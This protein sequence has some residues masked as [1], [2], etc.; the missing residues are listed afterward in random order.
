MTESKISSGIESQYVR[1]NGI[2]MHVMQSGVGPALVMIHGGMSTA[3]A[4]FSGAIQ[5]LSSNFKIIA[6]DSRGHGMTKNP[7]RQLSYSLMADDIAELISKIRL[8]HPYVFGWSDGGQI[9]L[10]L[11]IR[12]PNLP[13][14]IAVGGAYIHLPYQYID[15][16]MSIGK[17]GPGEIDFDVLSEN[18]PDVVER[19]KELHSGQG[20]DYW[21]E[22]YLALS[23]AQMNPPPYTEG[24]LKKIIQP[25]LIF[26]GDR[27]QFIPVEQ[28]IEMY[29]LIPNA[30]LAIVPD[31]DHSMGRNPSLIARLAKEFFV[32]QLE[33]K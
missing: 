5:E 13:T 22:L 31:T 20:E 4:N 18:I 19:L 3:M 25:T 17:R 10:D 24:D 28:A 30:E 21:K 32:K 27:D 33:G 12:Y 6:P 9:A 7:V 15:G 2:D 16:A 26:L 23:H 8:N 1:V 11:A 29:R 14:A